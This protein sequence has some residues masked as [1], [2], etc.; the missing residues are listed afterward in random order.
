MKKVIISSI[1]LLI[2]VATAGRSNA[3]VSVSINIGLQPDWGPV[4][5]DYVEYYY[6]PEYEIYYYVPQRQF[7]YFDA[8]QWL[9]VTALPP[10]YKTV[11]L[12]STYKVVINEPKAYVHFDQDK[13]KYAK[14][15]GGSEKQVVI[16]DS[17]DPKY[18]EARQHE[19]ESKPK[20]AGQSDQKATP[21]KNNEKKKDEKKD[22]HPD[23]NHPNDN[24]PK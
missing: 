22:K 10:R 2:M 14:Y 17:K 6:L 24:T 23:D 20:S 16:R 15:K 7:V 5:Y 19:S 4:G 3:Q 21:Q 13:V 1:I 9:F 8:G 11:N 12:Y 18:K